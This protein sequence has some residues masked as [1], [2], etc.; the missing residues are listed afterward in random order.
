MFDLATLHDQFATEIAPPLEALGIAPPR[1]VADAAAVLDELLNWQPAPPA[2]NV[3]ALKPGEVAKACDAIA[4]GL[5][6]KAQIYAVRDHLLRPLAQRLAGALRGHTDEILAATAP[7]FTAAAERFTTAHAKLP[8]GWSDPTHLVAAGPAAVQAHLDA[9]AEVGTLNTCAALRQALDDTPP[10]GVT[11]AVYT[12]TGWALPTN[13]DQ[14]VAVGHSANWAT[15]TLGRWGAALDAGA[16]LAW[17]SSV[18]AHHA[19]ARAVPEMETRYFP[20]GIGMTESRTPVI[21]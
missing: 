2:V 10:H 7:I 9:L 20:T 1:A 21:V 16:T 17:P 18:G 3:N 13:T 5:A 11:P 15:T 8:A 6:R 19:A 12:V 14:A 4:D